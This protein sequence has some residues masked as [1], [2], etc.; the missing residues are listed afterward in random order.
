MA[1]EFCDQQNPLDRVLGG[2]R[3]EVSLLH[4]QRE[5][6]LLGSDPGPDLKLGAALGPQVRIRGFCLGD[7]PGM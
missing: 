1:L 7:S 2:R 3:I 5:A 6:K 4:T